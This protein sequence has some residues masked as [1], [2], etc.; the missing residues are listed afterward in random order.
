MPDKRLIETAFPLRQASEASLHEKNMR[1]GHISTLHLWP[2]RRPLAASRAAIA[3]ALLPDPGDEEARKR[4][5]QRLGG[6]LK[7]KK[8]AKAEAGKKLEAAK[9]EPDGGILWWGQENLPDMAWFREQIRA[10]HGGRSPRVLDPFA[11]GG[12]IPLEAMRL[13]CEVT[14]N[15]L[16]PVAWF[17]LKCTL[18][19]PQRL[20]GQ[21]RPL[22]AHAMRDP[23]F[24]REFLKAQGFKNARLEEAVARMTAAGRGEAVRDDVLADRPW[25][26]A[27]LGWHVRAWGA[28]VLAEARRELAARYPTYAEWQTLD[29]SILADPKP[30]HLL[31]PGAEL[32]TA[33]AAL[34][35]GISATDLRTPKVPRWVAK[36]TVA[37]LWARTVP[38]KH[39]RATVPLLK[40]RWL[41]KRDGKRVVLEM[42]PNGAKDGVVFSV[43]SGVPEPAGTAAQRKAADKALGGGTMSRTGVRCPCC[44]GVMTMD[45]LRYEGRV[46]RLGA[47]MT[48][49]VV[50][51]PSGK[52]YRR[53]TE[54]EL[55]VAQVAMAEVEATFADVPFGLPTEPTPKGGGGAARAFSVGGYGL[56]RWCDLFTPRQLLALGTFVRAVRRLP[57]VL[58]AAGYTQDWWQAIWAYAALAN[59]RMADFGSSIASWTLLRE[60]LRG[61][62]GRFALPIVW[63]FTEVNPFSGVTGD[64]GGAVEWTG[65]VAAHL[66]A[67]TRFAEV[68]KITCGSALQIS[69]IYDA[70]ITDPPYYDAIPYSDL[71]DFFYVWLRRSLHGLSPEID[72]AFAAPLGPKWSH[73]DH[74]GEL[75]DDSSRFGGDAAASK[76]NFEDGMAAV[77]RRCHA[78]LTPNGVLVIVFANKNPDAWETL[79]GALIRA[80][81]V[82]DGSLPIATERGA[83]NR[84]IASAALSSSVWL[85]CRKRPS[86]A[87]PGF[88]GPV[89]S[90]MR[91]KIRTQMHRFWDAGI[92]G[93]DFVWAATGPALEAYSR[94]PVVRRETSASGQP[95]PLPVAEFLREVRRLVV[96]FAVG[97]VLKPSDGAGE[98]AAGL[99][100]ITTYY[101]L[102]RDSFG[103][104]EAPI[105]AC[106]LYALSC[107]LRDDD[108]VDRFEI[109]ARSGGRSADADED[110]DESEE[111]E[112][113]DGDA[114]TESEGTGSKVRLRRWDQRRRKTLGEQVPG[115][116]PVPLID[117][118]HRLMQL[119][120][121]GDV[122]K[123][124]AYLDQAG[125]ARDPLFAQLIQAL[126]ELANR[127]E[128]GDEAS[129]L[130]SI[131]NH[132]RSRA[133]VSEP[134]QALL[135]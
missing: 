4:L 27:G 73:E 100:D 46:G 22:P 49:V 105:G 63:D 19:Y 18:E 90:E 95:E 94:H 128:K 106:I 40:T 110:D 32:E 117:R 68:P 26:R 69:G 6:G 125:L 62:F 123:V 133:G 16:N 39:C 65:K 82:V 28:W 70:I 135:F 124:N 41:C 66:D 98:D 86:T 131:S 43:R 36:P 109:L 108:L 103:M 31:P 59:D 15:D 72:E 107:G 12:A 88:A 48:A 29:A 2:A 17:I 37:Y 89:L 116:G 35:A 97:R 77:F 33:V 51:G 14:A 121:A 60:T 57:P 102:H 93:P 20:A 11:G 45:D 112:N 44:S 85:V 74:D 91:E 21:T 79:V 129:I 78:A 61:T 8:K 84:A 25:E 23:A 5:V 127:D 71:M 30:L 38:C 55:A 111:A 119:W 92:R 99:D 104:G 67:A 42:A 54:H 58:Q 53:P 83:R 24:A 101:I 52:E 7:V 47:V 114:G 1:H 96:E 132:L 56:L 134:A 9:V 87:R 126:I 75:I 3:A 50:D 122:T 10:A 130:E 120:K 115:G 34:N 113:G 13:G 76:K 118:A 64:Y 81:F 80:G